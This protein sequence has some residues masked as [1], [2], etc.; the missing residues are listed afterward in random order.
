MV[1]HQDAI[2]CL[3]SSSHS[4]FSTVIKNSTPNN[5]N[6]NNTNNN[7]YGAN[8]LMDALSNSGNSNSTGNTNN[9]KTFLIS[10]SAERG[11][12]NIKVWDIE[13]R[14]SS[15]SSIIHHYQ[16][17]NDSFY[18]PCI[19]FIFDMNDLELQMYLFL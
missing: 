19:S 10:G 3:A 9:A 8:E 17:R 13:V 15:N 14:G 18:S 11:A 4:Y 1:D 5:N 2:T 7:S 16:P 6:N 12:G